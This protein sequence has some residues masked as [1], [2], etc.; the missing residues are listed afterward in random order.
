MI[1]I[2]KRLL[3]C[4]KLI[5]QDC[6]LADIGTDHGYLA[7]YAIMNGISKKAY[8]CDI[9][10]GP[11][12]SAQNT[13]MTNNLDEKIELVLSDGLK[14]VNCDDIT[15][16]VIAGMGGELIAKIIGDT[17]LIEKNINYILQPMTKPEILRKWLY[18]N[19]YNIITEVNVTDDS[20]VYTIMQVTYCGKKVKVS[21]YFAFTG[22]VD[23]QTTDGRRYLVSVANRIDNIS[24]GLEK[25]QTS[26][27]QVEKYYNL[28]NQIC[29]L[30]EG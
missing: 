14:N 10:E 1:N 16:I 27:Y 30:L 25:S 23:V 5:R 6:V 28:Y 11:L 4:V 21:D 15:D 9:N 8:A 2:N 19:G 20:F 22:K 13:I 12:K 3:E 18:E 24:K 17:P 26:N 29:E 7:A